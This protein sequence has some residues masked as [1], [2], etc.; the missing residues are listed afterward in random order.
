M[1][2]SVDSMFVATW[3]AEQT[4]PPV[5][6]AGGV[7]KWP[8]PPIDILSNFWITNKAMHSHILGLAL[9]ELA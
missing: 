9:H 8:L 2:R 6:W 7:A 5:D 4:P 3:A 1:L